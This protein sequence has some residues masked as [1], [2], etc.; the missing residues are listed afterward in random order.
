MLSQS[1]RWLSHDGLLSTPRRR[2]GTQHQ[3]HQQGHTPS[4][5]H[6]P[7]PPIGSRFADREDTGAV[8]DRPDVRWP[9]SYES[10]RSNFYSLL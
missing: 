7:S 5:S 10:P 9:K 1:V 2:S 8:V 6:R 4:A 3:R